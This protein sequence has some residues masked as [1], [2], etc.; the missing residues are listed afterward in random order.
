[1]DHPYDFRVPDFTGEVDAAA[2]LAAT[3]ENATCK[4]LY[5][6]TML[7]MMSRLPKE[8]VADI[9]L[10][11]TR[12]LPFLDY[13]LLEHMR[14]SFVVVPRLYPGLPT[15]EAFRR[16][17]WRAFPDFAGTMLGR[18]VFGMF[19]DDLGR[20]FEAGPKG[21]SQSVRPGMATVTTIA[22]RHV[23]ME[24]Y[25]IYGI[26]DPYYIGVVEG[27]VRHFGFEPDVRIH[28]IDIANAVLDVRW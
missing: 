18:V 16:M 23:R 1:M 4:G 19:G 25:D 13:P 12:Y 15:R 17:G 10:E 22:E 21:V 24:Y 27:M 28:A 11:R 5:F 8:Q 7:E 9:T 14:L 20:A 2:F 6:N 3:P 26:L